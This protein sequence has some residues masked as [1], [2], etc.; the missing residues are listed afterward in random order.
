MHLYA[1]I[2]Y[3]LPPYIALCIMGILCFAIEQQKVSSDYLF[4]YGNLLLENIIYI[5]TVNLKLL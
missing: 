5:Q 4:F 2:F 3:Y 1:K